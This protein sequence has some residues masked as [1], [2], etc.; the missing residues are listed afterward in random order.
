[1][2][3]DGARVLVTGASKGIG[4]EL[5]RS[6]RRAGADVVLVARSEEPLKEVAAELAGTY[7]VADLADAS[8]VDGL[9]ARVEAEGGEIDVLVN[10]AGRET[11]VLADEIDEELVDAVVALNLTAPMRLCRQ[12]LP[13][14]IARGRGH[15]VNVS[16]LAGVMT[17]QGESVYAATKAGLSHYTGCLVCDLRGTGVGVTLVEPGPVDTEMWDR[18]ERGRS[19]EVALRR[20]ARLRLIPKESARA[21]ADAT[22]AAVQRDRL[23]VRFPKRLAATFLLEDAPRVLTRRVVM[24]GVKPVR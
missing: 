15:V 4:R 19:L 14:M 22:V 17:I 9:V 20:A 21:I 10:N 11:N 16:S 1:M 3:L 2:E 18:F 5:A 23:H 6:F 24:A 12:A 13:G 7:V 8:K